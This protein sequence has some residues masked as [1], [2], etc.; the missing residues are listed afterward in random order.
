MP[1]FIPGLELSRIFYQEAV[2][3]IIVATLP[4]IPFSAARIGPGSEVLGFDTEMSRDHDWGPR[5]T[6]FLPEAGFSRNKR[7]LDRALREKLPLMLHGYSTS[8]GLPQEDG[9][10]ALTTA[11][12]GRVN[13][14][15]EI[16]RLGDYF[17][18]NLG[19][20]PQ[21]SISPADW[22]FS[23]QQPLLEMTCGAV[24]HDQLGLKTVRRRI[25]WF[26]RDIWIYLLAAAWKRIGQEEHLMG[27]AGIA[28]DELGSKLISAR[29]VRD[30][31]RLGFLIE[32]RYAPY[33]KWFGTA[34]R[35]LDCSIEM[36]PILERVLSANT[37]Q[38]RD[39]QL[40]LGYEVMV[41]RFNTLRILKPIPAKAA[42]FYERPFHVIWGE[43][44]A[45]ELLVRIKDMEVKRIA[46]ATLAGSVDLWSDNVDLLEDLELINRIKRTI[47]Q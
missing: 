10:W 34:Y 45:E 30:L 1:E 8:W 19:F 28:G 15:V 35:Q 40:A 6:L 43:K 11:S 32:K 18:G 20:D 29:L 22:L 37:W 33:A 44:I 25:R 23:P 2:K 4:G 31:M 36:T 16:T 41:N 14:R 3:P 9:S 7:V 17:M 12:P 24:F 42:K 47:Y 39:E 46:A 38:I 26:P 5:L 13:H 21:K 27:R